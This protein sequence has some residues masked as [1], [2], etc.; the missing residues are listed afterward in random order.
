MLRFKRESSDDISH[1]AE[2]FSLAFSI[3]EVE[4]FLDC[5]VEVFKLVEGSSSAGSES[6]DDIRSRGALSRLSSSA[7]EERVVDFFSDEGS[8]SS[9]GKSVEV[10]KVRK[11]R[12][13]FGVLSLVGVDSV[14]VDSVVE[15][16][17]VSVLDFDDSGGEFLEV[18][19]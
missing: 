8:D 16:K 15:F 19:D 12:D 17:L 1:S 11:F 10:L 18:E 4:F 2:E 5:R 7:S 9:E 13:E 6:S 14:E 3:E